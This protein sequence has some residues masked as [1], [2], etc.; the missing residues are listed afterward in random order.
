MKRKLF[1]ASLSV[2]MVAF[3]MLS[4]SACKQ[5]PTY[6]SPYI[7]NKSI[8]YFEKH[9]VVTVVV[10][11]PTADKYET[12]ATA[13]LSYNHFP[14][15]TAFT[16]LGYATA[17]ILEPNGTCTLSITIQFGDGGGIHKNTKWEIINFSAVKI[18][19]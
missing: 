3:L 5:S 13:R 14:D 7:E 19:E 9:A 8:Q 12:T 6:T 18:E 1:V 4:L 17:Q 10:K 2:I 11:N 16:D 15:N